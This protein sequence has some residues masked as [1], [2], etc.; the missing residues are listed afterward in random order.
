MRGRRKRA[1]RKAVLWGGSCAA[2]KV[3]SVRGCG[4]YGCECDV[5]LLGGGGVDMVL[6]L[7]GLSIFA[8]G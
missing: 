3:V 5:L 8:M 1:G 6:L 7:I 2:S 4:Y